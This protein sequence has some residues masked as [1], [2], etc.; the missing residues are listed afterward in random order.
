MS[1]EQDE[2][3]YPFNPNH[4]YLHKQLEEFA[5]ETFLSRIAPGIALNFA[6]KPISSG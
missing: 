1:E 3:E 4:E 6:S 2:V 5:S